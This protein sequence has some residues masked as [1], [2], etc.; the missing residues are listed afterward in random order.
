MTQLQC[1]AHLNVC[2]VRATRLLDDCTYATGP[3]NSVTTISTVSLNVTPE[4]EEGETIRQLNGCGDVCLN[5]N[6]P[7]Q[8]VSNNIEIE[9][10]TYDIDL[11]NILTCSDPV[12][13]ADGD[14]IGAHTRSGV[15]DCPGAFLEIWSRV[16]QSTGSCGAG[17]AAALQF[18]RRVYPR[19]NLINSSGITLENGFNTF[20]LSGTAEANPNALDGPFS[21]LPAPLDDD[22]V[23]CWFY[24]DALPAIS[25]CG[26][27]A[28]PVPADA[29]AV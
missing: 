19:V 14:S 22:I 24:D 4:I 11:L 16:G 3:E 15:I 21:D 6:Q 29:N 27:D 25:D 12:L 23:D 18:V 9:F 13:N 28:A 17:E 5:I 7:D 8:I 26:Y 1:A 2:A 10:C 20:T